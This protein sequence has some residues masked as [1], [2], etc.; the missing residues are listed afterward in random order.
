MEDTPQQATSTEKTPMI[1]SDQSTEQLQVPS[2]IPSMSQA[3]EA[4][5]EILGKNEGNR[6]PVADT[7]PMSEAEASEPSSDHGVDLPHMEDAEE[8]QDEKA[9]EE[10]MAAVTPSVEPETTTASEL[11]LQVAEQDPDSTDAGAEVEGEKSDPAA[12]LGPPAVP[13]VEEPTPT[14]DDTGSNAM[15]DVMY[16]DDYNEFEDNGGDDEDMASDTDVDIPTTA[17]GPVT[18]GTL[19]VSK[20]GEDLYGNDD[21]E[22]E[23]DD[24]PNIEE[25]EATGVPAVTG[26]E[27]AAPS[28]HIDTQDEE[29]LAVMENDPVASGVDLDHEDKR[30]PADS[31][32]DNIGSSEVKEND[33]ETAAFKS[34]SD[35]VEGEGSTPSTAALDPVDEPVEADKSL[36]PDDSSPAGDGAGD[37]DISATGDGAVEAEKSQEPASS[38]MNPSGVDVDPNDSD[39]PAASTKEEPNNS[40]ILNSGGNPEPYE[41][42]ECETLADEGTHAVT[43]V[44]DTVKASE[45]LDTADD[46]DKPSEPAVEVEVASQPAEESDAIPPA[47]AGDDI[48]QSETDIAQPSSDEPFDTSPRGTPADFS[49]QQSDDEKP[50]DTAEESAHTEDPQATNDATITPDE[51]DDGTR[52]LISDNSNVSVQSAG[53]DEE[54]FEDDEGQQETDAAEPA[55]AA[56]EDA[57]EDVKHQEH[58]SSDIPDNAAAPDITETNI[59]APAA[60]DAEDTFKTL[61]ANNSEVSVHSEPYEDDDFDEGAQEVEKPSVDP[62]PDESSH[63]PDQQIVEV[64]SSGGNV[65]DDLSLA[66]TLEAADAI[67]NKTVQDLT[68][69][70]TPTALVEESGNETKDAAIDE[71]SPKYHASQGDDLSTGEQ[72]DVPNNEV[73]TDDSDPAAEVDQSSGQHQLHPI[74]LAVTEI[75]IQADPSA[76]SSDTANKVDPV[77]DSSQSTDHEAAADALME[78][79]IDASEPR[80]ITP[81]NPATSIEA[82]DATG[83]SD[84][85]APSADVDSPEFAEYDGDDFDDAPEDKETPVDTVMP[86]LGDG[87]E[88]ATNVLDTEPISKENTDDVSD[89]STPTI[90]Q[91]DDDPLHPAPTSESEPQPTSQPENTNDE[92]TPTQSVE[93][94]GPDAVHEA[95]DGWMPMVPAPEPQELS[96]TP[97]AHL[98][99]ESSPAVPV[100]ERGLDPVVD[101]TGE[102]VK[103]MATPETDSAAAVA[104]EGSSDQASSAYPEDES[105]KADD[106]VPE[107]TAINYEMP[108]FSQNEEPS[109][110]VGSSTPEDEPSI[111]SVVEP[112]VEQPP[113]QASATEDANAEGSET[114]PTDEPDHTTAA[115]GDAHT[116]DQMN[117]YS[118][119]ADDF[120]ED[121]SEPEQKSTDADVVAE[122]PMEPAVNATRDEHQYAD[123]DFDEDATTSL[124]EIPADEASVV[125]PDNN[126]D[127]AAKDTPATED[128]V[129]ENV[130]SPP[131][132][133][134]NYSEQ[135]DEIRANEVDNEALVIENPEPKSVAA[136][137]EP[138]PSANAYEEDFPVDDRPSVA[139]SQLDAAEVVEPVIA[140]PEPI[141]APEFVAV[142]SE[143]SPSTNAYEEDFPDDDAPPVTQRQLGVAEDAVPTNDTLENVEQVVA[144]E[145]E[146]APPESNPSVAASEEENFSPEDATPETVEQVTMNVPAVCAEGASPDDVS[147]ADEGSGALGNS[148]SDPQ[149]PAANNEDPTPVSNAEDTM[150]QTSSKE[151]LYD[152]GF[153]EDKPALDAVESG[154]DDDN[155][156]TLT[157]AVNPPATPDIAIPDRNDEAS[158]ESTDANNVDESEKSVAQE[159]D[160]AKAEDDDRLN[161]TLKPVEP[162]TMESDPAEP[163]P[164]PEVSEASPSSESSTAIKGNPAAETVSVTSSDSPVS[165][166]GKDAPVAATMAEN[167]QPAA[168]TND[169]FGEEGNTNEAK[170]E[171]DVDSTILPAAGTATDPSLDEM[172]VESVERPLVDGNA[173]NGTAVVTKDKENDFEAKGA[174]EAGS[175]ELLRDDLDLPDEEEVTHGDSLGEPD[176]VENT[177]AV[178]KD[179]PM[180][181]Y[182]QSPEPSSDITQHAEHDSVATEESQPLMEKENAGAPI[183]AKREEEIVKDESVLVSKESEEDSGATHPSKSVSVATEESQPPEERTEIAASEEE[184]VKDEPAEVS[185][186]LLN[187]S[188]DISTAEPV[189]L[190]PTTSEES[191][192]LV[193]EQDTVAPVDEEYEEDEEVQDEL[194]VVSKELTKSSPDTGEQPNALVPTTSEEPQS[195]VKEQ[196]TAV[197]GEADYDD[198]QFADEPPSV[199]DKIVARD[200]VAVEDNAPKQSAHEEPSE[201]E[202]ESPR[203]EEEEEI[204]KSNDAHKKPESPSA[205]PAEVLKSEENGY[206][207]DDGYNEFDDQDN[208]ESLTPAVVSRKAPVPA[209]EPPVSPTE[210]EYED[211]EN[212]E[213]PQEEKLTGTKSKDT[214]PVVSV[215]PSSTPSDPPASARDEDIEEVAEEAQDAEEEAYAEEQD[216]NEF[217]E[218]DTSPSTSSKATPAA[219]PEDKQNKPTHPP[220]EAAEGEGDDYEDEEEYGD[221]EGEFE[222]DSPR[223]K[224]IT[225]PVQS[226]ATAKSDVDE[227]DDE[228]GYD[229]EYNESDD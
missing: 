25:T 212:D 40:P 170:I 204:P 120:D 198:E 178:V 206:D 194:A 175:S 228:V 27:P 187:P 48:V 146:D 15:V 45:N 31:T 58:Q 54:N 112:L 67:D 60:L 227:M 66:E 137:L 10:T 85:A 37:A 121:V 151:E 91:E 192:P 134:N 180:E 189:E 30:E 116:T 218:D 87:N 171:D 164:D 160:A 99:E 203:F 52:K 36:P 33:S 215:P 205:L 14:P 124:N 86:D 13:A 23:E 129:D 152:E 165:G 9:G 154:L 213:D 118:Q 159:P 188:S 49:Q 207:D 139:H 109:R 7:G 169:Q 162:E 214:P 65:E 11:P 42:R 186:E 153:E 196:N 125:Q 41:G 57:T 74:D 184:V 167:D 138:S 18:D 216:Y 4:K 35:P 201:M 113:E 77:K 1:P 193:N 68:P 34:A 81:D 106:P 122:T 38:T 150:P 16:G 84:S 114:P 78:D 92:V 47:T 181:A 111:N 2:E 226:A 168:K 53:Y 21:N 135:N 17:T 225:A 43:V 61:A 190:V 6:L 108:P 141:T 183:D 217:E 95:D 55:V 105:D 80:P 82:D 93:D 28:S 100:D 127:S 12:A 63:T 79:P 211:F 97:S 128:P 119:G 64:K 163:I 110:Q 185:K 202:Y 144:A 126:D 59:D 107:T 88:N 76:D 166:D 136:T 143:P 94:A 199:P 156:H 221:D 195:V 197:S 22:F 182:K 29:S 39:A 131:T 102:A 89:I 229:S 208:S 223:T 90:E 83:P 177:A 50:M 24:I 133:E 101:P 148:D 149:V 56:T 46:P 219:A 161:P 104:S 147:A 51:N 140:N 130:T 132:I 115:S 210:D 200:K 174:Q 173:G 8:I 98:D 179:D 222:K 172:N 209:V 5:Q 44:E 70:D 75:P 157:T 142:T 71:G 158:A 3:D 191:K 155:D 176:G 19:P 224:P 145:A 20:S 32:S 123:A 72:E 103:D 220:V 62:V 117:D 26:E 96:S 73:P 69:A